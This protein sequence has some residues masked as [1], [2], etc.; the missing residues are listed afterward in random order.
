MVRL[1]HQL[2]GRVQVCGGF[3]GAE[4][5]KPSEEGNSH[6]ATLAPRLRLAPGE[7]QTITFALAW[8]FPVV[9][10]YWD[11]EPE[12]KGDRMRNYYATRFANAWEA[13]RYTIENLPRLE[14]LSRSFHRTFFAG[15]LPAH[16]L[17]A[18]S[19]QV[20]IIRTSTCLL[21]EGKQFYAFEGCADNGGCC[22]MNCTH[23]WNYEQALAFLFPE[24]ERSMRVTDF[25][26][27]LHGDGGMSFRTLVPVGQ[28]QWMAQGVFPTRCWGSGSLT[29]S[30]S[31]TC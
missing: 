29:S 12:V 2:G 28:A 9:E 25:K 10:N 13:G 20:S 31:D 30:D 14:K 11:R 16:V 15:S 7:S 18:V 27:N 6:V 21:F 4:V 22:P 24:L 23:V 3:Q 19:S 17:D 1:L 26:H 5:S 8:H